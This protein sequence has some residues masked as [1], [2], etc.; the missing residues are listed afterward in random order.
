MTQQQIKQIVVLIDFSPQSAA[1]VRWAHYWQQQTGAKI[2]VGHCRSYEAPP[3]FT[4]EQVEGLA[5]Q[6]I[7]A[8]DQAREEV[9]VFLRDQLGTDV[10]WTII[11]MD[12]DPVHLLLEHCIGADLIIMGT[13]GRRG[14]QRWMLGSVAEAMIRS[15]T[16]PVLVVRHPTDF[17]NAPMTIARI[18]TPVNHSRAD[19]VT[20]GIAADLA[21]LFGAEL[22]SL[23][24]IGAQEDS[25][26]CTPLPDKIHGLPIEHLVRAGK[27]SEVI[28]ATAQ[29]IA[30]NLI[31]L[32]TMPKTFLDME[33][34]PSTV[35]QVLQYGVVPVL[36]LPAEVAAA[37]GI[38]CDV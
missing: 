36:V 21:T 15:A 14:L 19:L 25:E 3:T 8:N 2:I 16:A 13:H 7:R 9:I 33:I 17:E 10:P 4:I 23:R 24:V 27:T 34:L 28:L 30:A 5:Q 38:Q 1:A 12:D 35:T 22:V 20:L 32:S 26:N 37:G 11:V 6:A 29:E 18:L 31:V